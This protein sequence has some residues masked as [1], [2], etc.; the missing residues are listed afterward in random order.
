M[1]INQLQEQSE[2]MFHDHD[3]VLW[4]SRS[5]LRLLPVPGVV[6]REEA[7]K[8]VIRARVDDRLQEFAVSPDELVA[9]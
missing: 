9:R 7:D 4:R 8:I 1:S 5:A 6:V 2:K 3:L